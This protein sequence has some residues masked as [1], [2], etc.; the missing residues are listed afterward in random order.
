MFNERNEKDMQSPLEIMVKK[1]I[2]HL[3]EMK[4]PAM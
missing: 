4:V 1:V 2:L 3:Q